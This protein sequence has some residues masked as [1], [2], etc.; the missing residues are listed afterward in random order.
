METTSMKALRINLASPEVIKSWSYGEVLK[1]ETINYRRLRPEKDGLFCEAIFGPTRDWQCYCGKY[2]NPRYKGIICEKCGVEVTRSSVRRERMGHIGLAAPVAHI[3]YTRR[4][5]S[6]LG[7][8]LDIS[9]RNLDRVLYFAQYIITYVDDD[10]RQKALKRLED[11]ISLS[12]RELIAKVNGEIAEAKKQRDR[13]LKDLD[14]QI[15]Q[16]NRE[17]D[18]KVASLFEPVIQQGQSLERELREKTGKTVRKAIN[19]ELDGGNQTIVEV[20]EEV[21]AKHISRVQKVVKERMEI[22]ETDLKKERAEKTEQ[23]RIQKEEIRA[24]A[25]LVMEDLR[26]QLDDPDVVAKTQNAQHRDELYE[27]QPFTFLSEARYRELKSRWG[28]IFKADMGA[29]AFYDILRR[30]DL[31]ALSERLW[32][33]ARTT[34]SMQKRKKATSRLKVVEAFRRSTNKPE[35]MILTV[36]PVIPPDLRPMVQLDGGRFATSDLNDLYRRVINRNNRLKRLL[37]LGAPDVIVRNEKRMLQEAVDSLIDNSQRGRMYSRRG[38]RELRSLSDMLKGKKGRFRRNLLGK[39]VDY[40][41]RSVIVVGPHLKLNQCGLPK[42]MALELFRPFV[43]AGLDKH[44]YTSNIKGAKRYIERN[45]PEVWEVLEEVIKERPVLLNRAPTLHRLGIQAFEP[46]L[47]EGSAIQLH[48]LVT[49]AFN[50]DFDGDQMAVHVPL[51]SKAVAEARELMLASKNLLK[52]ASGEPIISPGKDMVLGVY[53]LTMDQN[54]PQ[55][56]DGRVFGDIDEVLLAYQ[57]KQVQVHTKIKL[58]VKTIFN[59]QNERLKQPEVRIIDTTVGRAIFN[60]VLPESMRFTNI[61]LDKGGVRDLIADIYDLDGQEITTQVADN[62]KDIGFRYASQSGSTLAVADITV[63]PEKAEMIQNALLEVERIQKEFRRGLLTEQEQNDLI[64]EVWQET[65]RNVGDAV[66][67]H[68]DPNG[69]LSTM[70][71]SGATKGGFSPISQMAGMRGLMA[72]PSGRIIPMPIRSNFREGLSA[73]EYFISTHGTR[74]GLADTAIRTADAG[75]L[76][77]RLVDV[78]QDVIINNE[79]CG[80]VEGVWVSSEDDVAGQPFNE[81]IYGRLL[82]ERVIDPV[83][84]E[85]IGEPNDMIDKA[86][87]L[88]ITK[89]VEKGLKKVKVRSP[90]TCELV[91]GICARCYGMDLGRGKMVNLGSAVGVVAAQSIG[92]PGTQLT[93]RTFHTGGVAGGGD[94]TT[95]LPRVEELFEARRMPRGEAV[96]TQI[97]GKAHIM[98]SEKNPDIRTVR[99]ESSEMVE[100]RYAIPAGWEIKVKDEDEVTKDT[101][102]ATHEETSITAEHAGKVRIEN[103][104]VVVSYEDRLSE[105]Y[106]IP[107]TSRLLISEGQMVKAGE[108]LT[109]GPLNP[110]TILRI[111]GTEATE[112]YLLKEIQQVYRTQG[113]NI[114]DKHFEVIIRKMLSR[115]QI[116]RP[117]DSEYLPQDLVDRLEIRKVNEDLVARGLR[118]AR[119]VN[120]LLGVSKASL[121]TDSFLS[122]S[123]FQHTIKVLAGAAIASKEDPLYGLKENVI[124]GKLIPAGTGFVPGR[125]EDQVMEAEPGNPDIAVKQL[126]IFNEELDQVESLDDELE[127]SEV[128]R[129]DLY[130]DE[131][132]E[133]EVDLMDDDE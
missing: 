38:R 18:E 86:L 106:E 74:K 57:L 15:E 25:E 119:Y 66:R 130:D 55:K 29:E 116:T 41:G 17:Y 99:V 81:R 63:P 94:I 88:Q 32:Q 90:L 50:A 52:P 39:R 89:L 16:I 75:Y 112:L 107:S 73:L 102:L 5:P 1:P 9:R 49:T 91:H 13:E 23:Y 46:V 132:F 72:D 19:F 44:G 101:V 31:D 133:D 104:E 10:G 93:L 78:A 70:A 84:G 42:S 115:V 120:V 47:I 69:N 4:I 67:K 43:I 8:L 34:K 14:A 24:K 83:T 129:F 128:G 58:R 48:P 35:W 124:I 87:S 92:E 77:R 22:L 60:D 98:V 64:I 6:Y 110:H 65:T 28:N 56:G 11:E 2:K 27:L 105:D 111:N 127:E 33:E 109:E 21:A 80:T 100:Q 45:R 79:D 103:G 71:V 12:E 114:N 40:S 30:L 61:P 85:V 7:L 95:G 26:S 126:D 125:F 37:E 68:L 108:Q 123:S 54:L 20:G 131:N 97:N 3:W 122:A 53:Y 62:I 117:G 82:A 121:S 76:T 59:D 96:I 36:L 51:S 113:Q 118:P